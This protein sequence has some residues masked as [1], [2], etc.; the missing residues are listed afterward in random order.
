MVTVLPINIK[1]HLIESCTYWHFIM[2]ILAVQPSNLLQTSCNKFQH[3]SAQLSI[4]YGPFTIEM[5][6]LFGGTQ[7][8]V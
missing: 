8:I 7:L 5:N 2:G 3:C 4:L 6:I 1:S